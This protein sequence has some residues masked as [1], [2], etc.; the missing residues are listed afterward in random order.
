MS[1]KKIQV[2][3]KVIIVTIFLIGFQTFLIYGQDGPENLNTVN[4]IK[5]EEKPKVDVVKPKVIVK[6]TV[7]KIDKPKSNKIPV[8]TTVFANGRVNP[9]SLIVTE[10]NNKQFVINLRTG[11]HFTYHN[12]NIPNHLQKV[13]CSDP[14]SSNVTLSKADL[15]TYAAFLFNENQKTEKYHYISSQEQTMALKKARDAHNQKRFDEI[16]QQTIYNP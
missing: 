6:P 11:H 3:S 12:K 14:Y 10:P 16:A 13:V 2:H 5:V 9:I 8:E 4:T 1:I 7:E 15:N